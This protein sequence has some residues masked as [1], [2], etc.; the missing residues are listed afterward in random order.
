[1]DEHRRELVEGIKKGKKVFIMSNEEFAD[2]IHEELREKNVDVVFAKIGKAQYFAATNSARKD[3]ERIL[4]E[5]ERELITMLGE[6]RKASEMLDVNK[7]KN[8]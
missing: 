7:Q 5:K 3:L 4:R 1:M 6:V 2:E 8:S